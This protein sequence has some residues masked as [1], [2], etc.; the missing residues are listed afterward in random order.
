MSVCVLVCVSTKLILNFFQ[1]HSMYGYN[2][3]LLS[4]FF[5]CYSEGVRCCW[6]N[7]SPKKMV[8]EF[9]PGYWFYFF[10]FSSDFPKEEICVCVHVC[11]QY[12]AIEENKILFK[13]MSQWTV[14]PIFFSYT[15][16]KNRNG[17]L[18][19]HSHF[20]SVCLCVCVR[21]AVK[22]AQGT[23]TLCQSSQAKRWV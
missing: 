7:L 21:V 17:C 9:F 12:N 4:V 10:F 16:K 5:A 8:S 14:I 2:F 20:V 6:Q 15:D 23:H 11:V 1:E 19:T 13:M 22:E 3:I 18:S